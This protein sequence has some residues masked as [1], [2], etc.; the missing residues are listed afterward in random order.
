MTFPWPV[1]SVIFRSRLVV[2]SAGK[3]PAWWWS[4]AIPRG[5]FLACPQAQASRHGDAL[6]GASAG[7]FTSWY[8]EFVRPDAF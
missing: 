5:C 1:S 6:P 3:D 7:D 2:R 4:V 8:P